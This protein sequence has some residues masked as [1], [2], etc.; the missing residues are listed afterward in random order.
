[1]EGVGA[2]VAA[3]LIAELGAPRPGLGPEQLAALAG[4]APLEASSAG[5]VRHRLSRGGNRRLNVLFYRI[6]LAQERTY[7]PAQ[8]YTAR[9]LAEGRTP[10]ETRRALKRQLVRRVWRHWRACWPDSSS[11]SA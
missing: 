9:R 6:A 1:M 5:A 10:H 11:T 4:V 8:A 7:P 2:L 3:G